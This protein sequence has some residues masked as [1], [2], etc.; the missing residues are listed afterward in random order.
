MDIFG[1][2]TL[3]LLLIKAISKAILTVIATNIC[4]YCIELHFRVLHHQSEK[5]GL[6]SLPAGSTFN[7]TDHK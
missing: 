1:L 4:Y 7:T 2:Y 6:P 3:A 5:I